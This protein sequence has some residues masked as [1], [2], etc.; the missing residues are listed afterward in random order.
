M[1]GVLVL[2]GVVVGGVSGIGVVCVVG[3][4][5]WWCVLGVLGFELVV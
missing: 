5:C 3:G 2:E 1:F 4:V